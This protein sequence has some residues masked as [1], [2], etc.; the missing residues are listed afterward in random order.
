MASVAWAS[1]QG[2]E[3]GLRVAKGVSKKLNILAVADPDS[4]SSKAVVFF[5]AIGFAVE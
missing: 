1:F 3:A 2:Q 4:L 5:R